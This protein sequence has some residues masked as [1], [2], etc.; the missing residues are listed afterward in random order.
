MYRPVRLSLPPPLKGVLALLPYP[1]LG[2]IIPHLLSQCHKQEVRGKPQEKNTGYNL[3][4]VLLISLFPFDKI[5]PTCF[6]SLLKIAKV[7]DLM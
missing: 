3:F 5:S 2:E 7:S 6:L 4:Q 1:P